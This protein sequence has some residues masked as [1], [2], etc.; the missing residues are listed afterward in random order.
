M[1]FLVFLFRVKMKRHFLVVNNKKENQAHIKRRK[2]SMFG[3]NGLKFE[4][5]SSV[6][7][8]CLAAIISSERNQDYGEKRCGGFFFR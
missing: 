5:V 3:V 8:K 4:G 7:L 2:G 1:L 6:E